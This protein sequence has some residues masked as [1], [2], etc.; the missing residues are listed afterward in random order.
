MTA[1]SPG[2]AIAMCAGLLYEAATVILTRSS[3]ESGLRTWGL[4]LKER[5]G[6]KRAAVA[7]ARKLAVIDA[8]DAEDPARCS[9]AQPERRPD[10]DADSVRSPSALIRP[11]RDVG[12]AIP[13]DG[14]HLLSQQSAA[15]TLEG[16][17]REAPSCGGCMPTAKTTLHPAD[18]H[19]APLI[20]LESGPPQCSLDPE[21]RRRARE[22]LKNHLQ[23]GPRLPGP[24]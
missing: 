23:N 12:R 14:V 1:I 21:P 15:S 19:M 16:S 4:A 9:T 7:V 24:G 2:G 20:R 11:C 10:R 18:A 5:I 17:S 3:A 6:F 13:P 22:Y 8:R